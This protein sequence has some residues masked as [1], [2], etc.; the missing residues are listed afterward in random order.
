MRRAP[1]FWYRTKREDTPAL[2]KMLNPFSALYGLGHFINLKTT[3]KRSVKIPV[4]CVGNIIA[5]GSGKTPALQSIHRLIEKHNLA[6]NPC[7]LSRGYGGMEIGP[8]KIDTQKNNALEV[9]DEP[10]LLARQC[11]TI[12]SRIRY[13]GGEYAQE[14]GHDIILMDDGMQNLSLHKDLTFLVINGSQGLGNGKL[15]PAGP[16]R[17]TLD[18]GL[19]RANA[20]LFIGEDQ[21]GIKEKIPSDV[22][23]FE[24]K[25]VPKF[26]G[27][28]SK[29]Y[30]GFAG[31][32]HPDKFLRTLE[33]NN[34]KLCGF[35]SFPDHHPYSDQDINTL[36]ERAAR[37]NADLIT[38]EKDHLR[39]S[40][41]NQKKITAYPIAIEWN[42]EEKLAEFIKNALSGIA[43]E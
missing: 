32:G 18:V 36:Y 24:G 8:L 27:N 19:R 31:I 28:T 40:Q 33:K 6:K 22:P 43:E 12:I 23:V 10:L 20:V 30:Y 1:S 17:E 5:G 35:K 3:K 34:I 25:I 37:H 42:D 39:L 9:G 2:E 13:K 7:F 14:L 26:T 16:L 38:T 11:P 21:R 29:T 41:K 4:I 15:I